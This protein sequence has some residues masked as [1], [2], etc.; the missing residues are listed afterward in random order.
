MIEFLA[1]LNDNS[2]IL[3]DPRAESMK[4]IKQRAYWDLEEKVKMVKVLWELR[5][6]LVEHGWYNFRKDYEEVDKD[7][8]GSEVDAKADEQ[9]QWKRR[10]KERKRI[11]ASLAVEGAKGYT[12]LTSA[13]R[14]TLVYRT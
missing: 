5:L 6:D 1:D 14:S 7:S 8:N 9:L 3:P 4:V 11:M 13:A 2:Y 12:S 10:V